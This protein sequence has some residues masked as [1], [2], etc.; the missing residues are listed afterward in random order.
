MGQIAAGVVAV[1]RETK[2]V[3]SCVRI[4]TQGA[5]SVIWWSILVQSRE[6][7][8]GSL[9]W[10]ARARVIS[11]SMRRLQNPLVLTFVWR[12]RVNERHV[13]HDE[14]KSLADG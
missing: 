4:T 11:A 14:K 5:R 10:S 8:G 6:A 3:A 2:S 7:A 13:K 9:V 12:S 1:R